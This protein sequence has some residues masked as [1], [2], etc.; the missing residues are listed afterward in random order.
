[1][2][3]P[4]AALPKA[5]PWRSV[6][7]TLFIAADFALLFDALIYS[8]GSG[9]RPDRSLGTDIARVQDS[10][11]PGVVT[12]TEN[13]NAHHKPKSPHDCRPSGDSGPDGLPG[14]GPASR[15]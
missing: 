10:Q 13:P 1:M 7:R 14:Y 9:P 12:K 8:E 3:E 6:P 4:V 2:D 5:M 11:P 15:T